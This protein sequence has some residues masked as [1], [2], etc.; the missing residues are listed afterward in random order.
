MGKLGAQGRCEISTIKVDGRCIAAL[1]AFRNDAEW[2]ALKV[3]Y[4]ERESRA[5]PGILVMQA[6]VERCCASPNIQRLD[7]VSHRDWLSGWRPRVMPAHTLYL[8]LHRA[9]APLWLGLLRLRLDHGPAA[10]Q[11]L[12]RFAPAGRAPAEGAA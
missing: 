9:T 11:W 1:L 8:A 12:R 6:A 3:C 7:L 10:R 2:A 4:D 5:S